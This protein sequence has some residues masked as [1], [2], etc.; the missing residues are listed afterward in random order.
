MFIAGSC[1]TSDSLRERKAEHE[2]KARDVKFDE[3]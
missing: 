3:N 1:P 2:Q